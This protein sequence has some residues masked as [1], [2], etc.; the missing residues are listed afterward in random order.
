MQ[1]A[2]GT[3]SSSPMTPNRMVL[4]T[5]EK[6]YHDRMHLHCSPEHQ[7]KPTMLSIDSAA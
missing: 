3:A 6:Y 4:A 1:A 5:K 2:T 7:W